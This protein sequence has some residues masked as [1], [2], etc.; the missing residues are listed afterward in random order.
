MSDPDGGR[1]RGNSY[2]WLV[3]NIPA[4]TTHVAEGAGVAGA[5]GFTQGKNSAGLEHYR[6]PCPGAGDQ[7]HH[8]VFGVYALD[9]EPGALAPG[10]DRAGLATAF[11][12][13]TLAYTSVVLRYAR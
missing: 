4:A 2:H 7:P 5:T 3:Y 9:L 11:A 13:H 12:D 10:L 6:G 8:Y 1:G